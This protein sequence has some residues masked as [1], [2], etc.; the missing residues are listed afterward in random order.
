MMLV[1]AALGN[2]AQV[3]SRLYDK[4]FS[5]IFR[6]V[7]KRKKKEV[8]KKSEKDDASDSQKALTE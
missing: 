4:D 5:H 3:E 1:G 7:R 8:A 6:V 2:G